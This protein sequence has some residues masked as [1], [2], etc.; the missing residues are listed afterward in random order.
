MTRTFVIS[1]THFGHKNILE[2]T[3]E[4]GGKIRPGFEDTD[5]MDQYM[6]DQWNQTVGPDDIV[7]HLGDFSMAKK[8][9]RL[10]DQLNGRKKLIRGNHDDANAKQYLK[11]FENVDGVRV[12]PK[13]DII[14]SHYP[15]HPDSLWNYK[16]NRPKINVH[17]H[18]H[19]RKVMISRLDLTLMK[20]PSGRAVAEKP[21]YVPDPRYIN[22]SVE[23]SLVNYTPVPLDT[24]IEMAQRQQKELANV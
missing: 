20:T 3:N 18:T 5:H 10:A 11:H 17:G 13:L 24:I 7:Y 16:R 9:I 15:L 22:V 2:F 12:F 4:S 23:Q 14:L 1:D 6:I 21:G 8:Y 19:D